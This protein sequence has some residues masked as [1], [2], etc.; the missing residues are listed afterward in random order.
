MQRILPGSTLRFD[1][2][3]HGS[4]ETLF[5][6]MFAG[7]DLML[8]Q[9]S[10]IAGVEPYVIQNWVARGFLPPPVAKRYS[11]RQLC[12]IL[13]I[14][15]LRSVL[16]LEEICR[17]LRYVNG[18]LDDISDDL[19]DDSVLYTALVDLTGEDPPEIGEVLPDYQEPFPGARRRVEQVLE[20][21]LL[22]YRAAVLKEQAM[23]YIG[24]LDV[25]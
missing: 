12:R 22:S 10:H 3:L 5:S 18:H 14:N 25:K 19:V 4:A 1:P 23:G 16:P 24:R 6:A 8:A 11:R 20:I 2:E 7:G 21:M 9:M 17:L 15:M 13:I